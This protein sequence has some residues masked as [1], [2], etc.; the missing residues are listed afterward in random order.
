VEQPVAGFD[1]VG[2]QTGDAPDL[3]HDSL[4]GKHVA[5]PQ[6]ALGAGTLTSTQRSCESPSET[7]SRELEHCLPLAHAV[8][9]PVAGFDGVAMH[10]GIGPDMS[11]T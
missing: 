6:L 5:L 7:S 4:A 11:Q 3:S 9:Q 1:G 2:M 10:L 8:E